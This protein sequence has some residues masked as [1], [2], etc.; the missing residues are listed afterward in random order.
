MQIKFTNYKDGLHQFDFETNYEELGFE[1]KT[2]DNV[3][4]NCEMDKSS[5]QI[6]INCK[7]KFVAKQT[8]DRCTAE[9]DEKMKTSFKNIYFMT[10]SRSEDEEDESG[11]YYLS[12][13][14]DKINLSSDTRENILLAIPMKVLCNE[15]C[16]GLCS[17]CGVDL[18]NKTC[19]CKEE[20]SNPV[21]DSLLKLKGKLN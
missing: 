6:V 15:D 16:K 14:E 3:L 5:S 18:N 1:E 7:V 4:L 11:I 20:R 8:C 9:F 21:W 19:N 10:H 13:E 17:K 2:I 12:P